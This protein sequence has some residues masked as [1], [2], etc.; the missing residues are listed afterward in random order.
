MLGPGVGSALEGAPA[1]LAGGSAVVMIQTY[2]YFG[3]GAMHGQ[4][5][6][7]T[8]VS[9]IFARGYFCGCLM[10]LQFWHWFKFI[11]SLMSVLA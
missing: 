8:K 10:A 9:L 11:T 6:L 4:H 1:A 2:L 5:A 3:Q 7:T